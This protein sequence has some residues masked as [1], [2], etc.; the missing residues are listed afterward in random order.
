MVAREPL[1]EGVCNGR[2]DGNEK[3]P[4]KISSMSSRRTSKNRR[5][6]ETRE[7]EQTEEKWRRISRKLEV[8]NWWKRLDSPSKNVDW[9]V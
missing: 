6:M 1:Q 7:E 8:Y 5:R 9:K 2:A 3:V 4:V